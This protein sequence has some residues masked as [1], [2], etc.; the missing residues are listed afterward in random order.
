MNRTCVREFANKFEFCDAQTTAQNIACPRRARLAQ[1][2]HAL[3]SLAFLRRDREVVLL[4]HSFSL[5]LEP[6]GFQLQ[7]SVSHYDGIER[8]HLRVVAPRL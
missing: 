6:H 1:R 7:S 3:L 2:A 4:L 5:S 8:L